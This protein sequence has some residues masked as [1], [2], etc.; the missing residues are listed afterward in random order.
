MSDTS[1]LDAIADA[2]KA[3]GTQRAGQTI[4]DK[5]LEER[6][7]IAERDRT[8]E[9]AGFAEEIIK[10][11]NERFNEREFDPAQRVFSVALA[12]VNLREHLPE[13]KGGKALFDREAYR[14]KL[15]Y[16]KN[17]D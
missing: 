14:A 11:L 5:T 7:K 8:L 13:E 12:T 3:T 17:K 9:A 4:S 2:I 10:W 6:Q 1:K 16:D 15:Y